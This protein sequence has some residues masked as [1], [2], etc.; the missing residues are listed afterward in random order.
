MPLTIANKN[1]E[2]IF[3][4][5]L[6][7]YQSNAGDT[8]TFTCNLSETIEFVSSPTVIFYLNPVVLYF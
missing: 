7:F 4:N 2:D 1:F 6:S 5:D 3:S 8:Q